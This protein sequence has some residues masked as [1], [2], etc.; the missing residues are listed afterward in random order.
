MIGQ[1]WQGAI[2]PYVRKRIVEKAVSVS[3]GNAPGDL[4]LGAWPLSGIG[5]LQAFR[6]CRDLAGE[7]GVIADTMKLQLAPWRTFATY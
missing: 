3:M 2:Q 7:R 5:R 4:A 1:W 6:P